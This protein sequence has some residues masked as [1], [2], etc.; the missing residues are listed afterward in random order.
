MRA[1]ELLILE[2]RL[3]P[4]AV[5]TVCLLVLYKINERSGASSDASWNERLSVC[6]VHRER[7]AGLRVC[8]PV[9]N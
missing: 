9:P 5:I 8:L 4:K 6:I 1:R 2:S 7:Q 3:N